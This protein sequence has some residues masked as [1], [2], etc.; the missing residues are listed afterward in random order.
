MRT[1]S[2]SPLNRRTGAGE[3]EDTTAEHIR[4][5]D[6]ALWSRAIPIGSTSIS[7]ETIEPSNIVLDVRQKWSLEEVRELIFCFYKAKALG[8]GYIKRLERLFKERNSNNPK[9]NKL[10]GN[11]LSNQARSIISRNILTKEVLS[12]IKRHAEHSVVTDNIQTASS[13]SD[14]HD[15]N[16]STGTN[17]IQQRINAKEVVPENSNVQS[18]R[19]LQDSRR[20]WSQEELHELMFCYYKTKSQG[21][22]YVKRLEKLFKERN[23]NNPKIEKFTGQLLSNQARRVITHK[24]IPEDI[25]RQIRNNAEQTNLYEGNTSS[26]K[27]DE[28]NVKTEGYRHTSQQSQPPSIIQNNEVNPSTNTQSNIYLNTQHVVHNTQTHIHNN[29]D[30]NISNTNNEDFIEINENLD[31]IL[32]EF[33]QNLSETKETLIENRKILPKPILSKKFFYN[34][35]TINNILPNIL[36]SQGTLRD[37]NDVIYAAAKTLIEANNQKPFNRSTTIKPFKDPPWKARIKKKID[38]IRKELGRLTE[39]KNDRIGYNRDAQWIAEI[40]TATGCAEGNEFQ[41]I[42]LDKVKNA[43]KKTQN[44]KTPG[45]DKIQNFYIK[46]LTNTHS[47][48]A[49]AFDRIFKGTEETEEW[50]TT[51]Q[52]VLIPKNSSD[53]DNPRNWRPIA[54]LPTMYKILTSIIAE[55]L[56]TYCE[57][58]KIIAVEQRGCRRGTR[59][60]KDHLML[61]KSILED[62]YYAKKNLSM[63]WIDYQKAFDSISHDWLL[64][65]L[66]IYKCPSAV[67]DFLKLF[68]SRWRVV[69]TARGMNS[70]V[71]TDPIQVKC[72]LFQGDS[73][74][75]LLFC[76]AINPL[77]Q[78][79]NKYANKGYKLKDKTYINHLVYMDDLK[80]YAKNKN[81]LAALLHTTE[82]F[83]NDI[84]MNF[85]FE[86]CNILHMVEGRKIDNQREGQFLL[87]GEEFKYLQDNQNYKYLGI[88]ESGKLNHTELRQQI[89]KEY[90]KR[91]KKL[92]KTHLSARNIIKA[93]N[94]Y[95]VPV[96]LY[97]FG[98][99]NYSHRDICYID[100]KTRKLLTL[101]KIHK[102]KSEVER[103]YLPTEEGGRGRPQ[104]TLSWLVDNKPIEDHVILKNDGKI[105]ISKISISGA[106]RSWLNT[107]V[108]CQATNTA[109]LSPH[110]RSARVEMNLRPTSVSIIEKPGQLS[111]DT[112]FTLVCVTHGSRPPAQVTWFRENRR[113]TRGKHSE[114]INDTSTISRLT[115]SPQPEDDGVM[116]RCRADNPVLRVAL[117]DSFRMSVVYKPVLT[118]SLGSTLNPNDIKEGD[119]VYF[120]CNIRANPKEHRTSWYHNDHQVTQNMSSGV[121]ISTKS[122][123]LQRVTRKDGGL[124][125]CKAANDMGETS[126]Q[127]VYL[128]VQ[129]APVCAQAT[130]RVVGARLD[131]PLL[132]RCAVRADPTDLTFTWQFNNSGES[133]QVSPARYVPKGGTASELRY[134]AAS[135][136]DYGALLCRASNSVGRQHQP[137]VFQIVPAGEF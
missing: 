101:N 28:Q 13:S 71:T 118:M 58:H 123:V 1:A 14:Q 86:K 136:R 5:D 16:V 106:E 82:I 33:M 126:S 73:L 20:K 132:V 65:V 122:L 72:G 15:Y 109:L 103:L 114:T 131:E 94:S 108:K 120:E 81:S 37:I 125:A 64:K 21:A 121:F 61:N 26:T 38:E 116:I 68:M 78:I 91:I 18:L 23:L 2:G 88:H 56:Y 34:L 53:T 83:T 90:F 128:R 60:C 57:Q 134:R 62:A 102:Q 8:I 7:S 110:E 63:S 29:D 25:L 36:R 96:L 44:W 41:D 100:I 113:Y 10:N 48:M 40:E 12:E 119:D 69:M 52:V 127:A 76:L 130:P 51:G 27:I 124:Y 135:E 75:P 79:L 67:K 117:E 45:I 17:Q 74:S 80:L 70:S 6:N 112:E 24:D 97:S 107:S 59:G 49:K 85:G 11:T 98:I 66:E 55:E 47:Y 42:D 9:V 32:I 31:S 87:S 30:E 35:N 95:A 115:M 39:S 105:I 54:C 84:G 4:Q 137:C 111:A 43:I 19:N 133:F 92:L 3:T 46:Y 104:P 129:F 50:F 99:V 89:S 93:I 22:G 77:S